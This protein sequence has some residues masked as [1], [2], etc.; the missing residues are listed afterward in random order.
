VRR[1]RKPGPSADDWA[2]VAPVYE[3]EGPRVRLGVLWFAAAAIAVIASPL[4]VAVAYGVAAGWAARQVVLAWR[5]PTIHADVAT[6]L[7]VVPIFAAVLGVGPGVMALAAVI[8]VAVVVGVYAPGAGLRGGA[9]HLAGIGIM[10]QAVVPV[11][12]AGGAMVLVRAQSPAAAIVLLGLA[13]AYEV[14]DFIV[15]SGSSTPVEGPLA[16]GA[17]VVLTGFPLALLLVE[18]FDVVGVPLLGVAALCC[19]VGQWIASAV[20][21]R[22]EAK[23]PALRRI[24]TLLMLAPVWAVAAGAV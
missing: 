19:P 9:G 18:P 24:D 12:V 14:G 23:A 5:S 10:I 6:G 21:P 4:T 1:R 22:P 3:V 17:A 16:G 15:G 8:V 13:S 2:R 20:L 7:A 11:A